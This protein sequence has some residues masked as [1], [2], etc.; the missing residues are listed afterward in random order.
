LR[1][2]HDTTT[3]E[4]DCAKRVDVTDDGDQVRDIAGVA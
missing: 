3:Q 1:F 2:D 4:M